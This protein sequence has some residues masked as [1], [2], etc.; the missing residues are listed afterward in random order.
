MLKRGTP[1]CESFTM[2][3]EETKI[4]NQNNSEMFQDHDYCS[5]AVMSSIHLHRRFLSIFS[6]SVQNFENF[7]H[8]R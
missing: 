1:I 7:K 2:G 8:I 5:T 6:V 3:K 4:M